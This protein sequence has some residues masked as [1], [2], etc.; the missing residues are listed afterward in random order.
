MPL[1]EMR[2]TLVVVVLLLLELILFETEEI[3]L[4]N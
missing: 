1:V 4:E 3:S 2:I